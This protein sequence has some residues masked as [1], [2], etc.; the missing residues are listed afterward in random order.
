MNPLELGE[1]SLPNLFLKIIGIIK[2]I[3]KILF[4]IKIAVIESKFGNSN[5]L[6]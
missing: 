1:L 4:P 3:L 5:S 6:N 2:N